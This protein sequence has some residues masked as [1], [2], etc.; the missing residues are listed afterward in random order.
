MRFMQSCKEKGN[1]EGPRIR[2]GMACAFICD[3]MDALVPMRCQ[4]GLRIVFVSVFV[5]CRR[6][7]IAQRQVEAKEGGTRVAEPRKRVPER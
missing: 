5:S 2:H 4:C 1:G 3:Q 6:Q 7:R